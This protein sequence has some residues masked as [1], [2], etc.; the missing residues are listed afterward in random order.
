[1]TRTRI[2][3]VGVAIWSVITL[4]SAVA[5]SFAM[6]FVTRVALG[7]ADNRVVPLLFQLPVHHA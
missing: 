2:I 4:G 1:V 7:A 3:G 6:F 5:V